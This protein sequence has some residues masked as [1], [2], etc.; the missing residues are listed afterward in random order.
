[1]CVCVRNAIILVFHLCMADYIIVAKLKRSLDPN[2]RIVF[3]VNFLKC[4]FLLSISTSVKNH[5]KM[6]FFCWLFFSSFVVLNLTNSSDSWWIPDRDW[7]TV[8]HL[9]NSLGV[10]V[11]LLAADSRTFLLKMATF[12]LSGMAALKFSTSY[13][14]AMVFTSLDDSGSRKDGPWFGLIRMIDQY[15]IM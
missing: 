8:D 5:M 13:L 9:R 15:Y 12:V 14:T 7:N 1:M 3:W 2:D 10:I 4:F 6:I 11:H